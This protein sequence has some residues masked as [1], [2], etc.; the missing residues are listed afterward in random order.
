M[1]EQ[2]GGLETPSYK[3]M[4]ES[5]VK[6]NQ[7]CCYIYKT[8]YQ[9]DPCKISCLQYNLTESSLVQNTKGKNLQ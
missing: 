5:R 9:K 2:Y 7:N 4:Y 6:T 1:L 8:G 3:H